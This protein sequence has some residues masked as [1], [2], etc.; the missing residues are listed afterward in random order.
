LKAFDL[1]RSATYHG[2]LA[3]GKTMIREKGTMARWSAW[4]LATLGAISAIYVA[5]NWQRWQ[6]RAEVA[7]GFGARTVC[8]CRYI[9]GRA[10]NSCKND[11]AGLEGMKLV[12]VS[13]N[14]TSKTISSAVPIF[15]KRHARFV[16][17]YGCMPDDIA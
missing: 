17:N 11:L 15:A 4:L 14:A 2:M 1:H 6:Q 10:L 16:S 12:R 3:K 13:E 9:E 8:S 5:I 7:A